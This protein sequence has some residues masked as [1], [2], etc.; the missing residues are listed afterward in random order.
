GRPFALSAAAEVAGADRDGSSMA[1]AAASV[2]AVGTLAQPAIA[3]AEP[4]AS[5]H[6]RNP[7]IALSSPTRVHEFQRFPDSPSDGRSFPRDSPSKKKLRGRRSSL[8]RSVPRASMRTMRVSN[9]RARSSIGRASASS[10]RRCRITVKRANS[11]VCDRSAARDTVHAGRLQRSASGVFTTNQSETKTPQQRPP[12]IR[13]TITIVDPPDIG[14]P[15][16]VSAVR[17]QDMKVLSPTVSANR[18]DKISLDEVL[19]SLHEDGLHSGP[20]SDWSASIDDP[21]VQTELRAMLDSAIGELPAH[22]RA[23]VVLHDVEGLSMAEVAGSLGITV[24]T[25]KS[26]TH[27]GRLFLRKRLAVFMSGATASIGAAS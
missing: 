3:I 27:R 16:E 19:P 1:E 2:L 6:H 25:A 15:E 13:L 11:M 4:S 26:R 17:R 8:P 22:Y 23:V 24:A 5:P 18:R 20:T 9:V 7:L 21:A 12:T 10:A 14:R